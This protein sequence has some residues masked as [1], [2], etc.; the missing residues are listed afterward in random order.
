MMTAVGGRSAS[1]TEHRRMNVH[2]MLM[3]QKLKN[4]KAGIVTGLSSAVDSKFTCC[5]YFGMACVQGKGTGGRLMKCLNAESHT[6]RR[7]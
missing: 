2:L 6:F 1:L 4:R 7:E 3:Q 5:S